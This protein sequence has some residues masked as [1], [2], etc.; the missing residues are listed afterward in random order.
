MRSAE[1]F[2]A[3]LA[4]SQFGSTLMRFTLVDQIV[5]HRARPEDYDGQERCRWPRSTW[6]TIFPAFP[7]MPGVLMLEA[8]TQAGAWLIRVTD[9]FCAQHRDA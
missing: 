1:R 6:P 4:Q 5:H 2:K 9:D 7:V 8:M 3:R